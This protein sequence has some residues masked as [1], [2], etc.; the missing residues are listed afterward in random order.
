MQKYIFQS[1]YRHFTGGETIYSLNTKINELHKKN[2]YPIIDF[3]KESTYN[4]HDINN[5][6]LNYIE[7]SNISK[8]DYI[9][10]KLSS[11]GFYEDKINC[12][13]DILIQHDKKVMID[14][15]GVDKQDKIDEITNN[16]ISKYN[17]NEVNVYKTYQMYRKDGLSK[18]QYDIHNIDNLG[19]KLVRGAYYNQDYK[20][21]KLFT[22]K[23]ET[24]L[25]YENAMKYIFKNEGLN[26]FICT[27]NYYNINLMIDYVKN[28]KNNNISHASLYGFINNDTERII[29]S[30]ISTYKYL[31]Y[32]KYEDSV[33]YLTR[34]IYENP[35]ILFYML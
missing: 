1:L 34:R 14:A 10:V 21:N 5:S 7:I 9:A 31:P 4:T 3:I 13:V 16:L 20:S 30:G 25:A 19:I 32:G 6:I 2:L 18:L 33:P 24:D 28:V 17:R 22:T 27:H 29:K 23:Y 26:T 11:F 8:I 15:E 35:K 12:L